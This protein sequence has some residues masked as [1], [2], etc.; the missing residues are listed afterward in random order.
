MVSAGGFEHPGE[1]DEVLGGR[2]TL[3]ADAARAGARGDVME[4]RLFPG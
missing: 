1:G 3:D 4:A 2:R